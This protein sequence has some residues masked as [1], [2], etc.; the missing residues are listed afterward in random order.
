MF[1]MFLLGIFVGILWGFGW[2]YF[3]VISPLVD[4]N[5]E[6]K[7]GIHDCIKSGLID[8]NNE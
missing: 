7:K 1:G 6:L 2:A 8:N 5:E 4:D 3:K